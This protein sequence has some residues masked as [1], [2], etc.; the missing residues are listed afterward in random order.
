[1]TNQGADDKLKTFRQNYSL[2]T[3][4]VK[5]HSAIPAWHTANEVCLTHRS[6]KLRAFFGNDAGGPP[7]LIIYSQVNKPFVMDLTYKHSMIQRLIET[8][9]QVYLLDWGEFTTEDSR[10]N[11]SCYLHDYLE[12]AVQHV[13]DKTKSLS[14]NMVGICQGG[15]FALCYASAC[16]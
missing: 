15:T 13:L 3:K 9:N 16:R 5:Y 2:L 11:L 1:M 8:G 10:S 6:M 7:V 14:L 4:R 12:I